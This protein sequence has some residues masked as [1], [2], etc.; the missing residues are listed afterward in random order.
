MQDESYAANEVFCN[1]TILKNAL[2]FKNYFYWRFTSVPRRI[3]QGACKD[4]FFMLSAQGR[5]GLVNYCIK[6]TEVDNVFFFSSL[7]TWNLWVYKLQLTTV[8]EPGGLKDLMERFVWISCIIFVRLELST[9]VLL[10]PSLSPSAWGPCGWL[11]RIY[12]SPGTH[13][14]IKEWAR[15][16]SL[17]RLIT[18]TSLR[19]VCSSQPITKH[20]LWGM[21]SLV[22]AHVML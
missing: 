3:S 18:V 9:V 20:T 2:G 13:A 22:C 19:P 8:K 15:W 4:A 1:F 17:A 11:L 5:N 14:Y 7:L 21:I 6:E 10:S 12:K 16:V